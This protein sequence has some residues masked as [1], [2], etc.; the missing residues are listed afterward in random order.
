MGR[1]LLPHSSMK[2]GGVPPWVLQQFVE[3]REQ[4]ALGTSVV[5][6]HYIKLAGEF[7]SLGSAT[8]R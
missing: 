2:V 1:L 8:I 7:H 4:A 3:P 6:L 5:A